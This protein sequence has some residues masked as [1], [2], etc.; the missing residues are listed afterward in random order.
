MLQSILAVYPTIESLI[1]AWKQTEAE[2]VALVANLPES[3][4][5]RTIDYLGLGMNLLIGLP[6]HTRG[7]YTQIREAIAAVREMALVAA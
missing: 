5:S 1:G 2:T 6:S 3:Y 4:T 7:H